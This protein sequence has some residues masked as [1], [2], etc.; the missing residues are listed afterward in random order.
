M[1]GVKKYTPV[2]FG[3]IFPK[4]VSYRYVLIIILLNRGACHF[5]ASNSLQSTILCFQKY[6]L[7]L[8]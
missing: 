7:N 8:V 4:V 1:S 3:I 2:T 6:T 5:I